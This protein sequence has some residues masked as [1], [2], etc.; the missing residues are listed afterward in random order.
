MKKDSPLIKTVNDFMTLLK[1]FMVLIFVSYCFSGITLIEPGTIGII[2]RMGKIAGIEGDQI[3]EPGWIFAFPR[4]IDSVMTIPV[5]QV[6][7]IGII[8]LAPRNLQQGFITTMDPVRQG[9][10][11]SGDENIFHARVNVKYQITDP[12]AALKNISGF[13]GQLNNFVG[14]F[15]VSE[16]VKVAAGYSIDAILSDAQETITI[17]VKNRVQNKL[18]M[19][20]SGITLLEIEIAELSVPEPVIDAFEDVNRAY[21]NRRNFITDANT[22]REEKIPDAH[23]RARQTVNQA[24]AYRQRLLAEANSNTTTFKDLM[25]AYKQSP[26]EVKMDMLNKSRREIFNKTGRVLV[27]PPSEHLQSPISTLLGGTGGSI[28]PS[29]PSYSQLYRDGL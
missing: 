7:S 11:I 19:I 1:V 13:P 23:A 27:L 8:E 20:K 25:T 5:E 26:F 3:K 9:Y 29:L 22:V 6:N 21:I 17:E 24:H 2:F 28:S 15:T 18:D 16:M 10:A 12:I 4:P 14:H